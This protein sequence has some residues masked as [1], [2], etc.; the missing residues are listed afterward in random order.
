[1]TT[2]APY[3]AGAL[4]AWT[5]AQ[6]AAL[7][8]ERYTKQL[9]HDQLEEK[10]EEERA[11]REPIQDALAEARARGDVKEKERLKKKMAK[12]DEKWGPETRW[13]DERTRVGAMKMEEKQKKRERDGAFGRALG[14]SAGQVVDDMV[15]RPSTPTAKLDCQGSRLLADELIDFDVDHVVE[16]ATP[17]VP[18]CLWSAAHPRRALHSGTPVVLAGPVPYWTSAVD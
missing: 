16:P 6:Q 8:A 3:E 12:L 4:S 13:D 5:P 7:N 18:R 10:R 2:L 11:E 14:V 1:M 9:T 17:C 15:S